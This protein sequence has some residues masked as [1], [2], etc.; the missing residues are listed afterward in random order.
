MDALK[1]AAGLNGNGTAQPYMELEQQ[2]APPASAALDEAKL[3]SGD[4]AWLKASTM[5]SATGPHSATK[6]R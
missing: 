4:G 2:A 3:F 6:A 1:Q 5:P